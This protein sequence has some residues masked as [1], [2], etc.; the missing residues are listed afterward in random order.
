MILY[1]WSYR[2]VPGPHEVVYLVDLPLVL[3]VEVVQRA[4]D[5]HA[6]HHHAA[7]DDGNGD[8]ED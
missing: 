3:P 1:P 5:A 7:D 4:A 6:Q 8:R 2:E